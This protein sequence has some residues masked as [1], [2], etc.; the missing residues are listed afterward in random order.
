MTYLK[1]LSISFLL[2]LA[3]ALSNFQNLKA[4]FDYDT[5]GS[6]I[7]FLIGYLSAGPLIA[8]IVFVLFW[9]FGRWRKRRDNPSS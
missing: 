8:S 1:V 3:A 4:R 5:T 2:S 6:A 7:G 9:A